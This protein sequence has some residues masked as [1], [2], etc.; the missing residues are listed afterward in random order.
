[1]R[2]L[3]VDVGERRIGLA[4]SDTSAVLATPL[5]VLTVSRPV[6]QGAVA[7]AR[8]IAVLI[9][10][11]DG[12]ARV[13]VGLPLSLDGTPHRLTTYV[14]AFVEA[15]RRYTTLPIHLQDEGLSSYEAESRLAQ[16]E[17]SWRRRK[18]RLDAA[19]AAIIL[20]DFLDHQLRQPARD[21]EFEDGDAT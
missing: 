13:V 11:E 7:V 21:P 8:E 17:K 6:K 1:M 18:V 20:Q 16:H 4:L 19:A 10:Q 14:M 2:V 3:G 5:R 9:G 12:L 15:L